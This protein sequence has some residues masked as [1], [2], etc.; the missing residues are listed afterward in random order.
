MHVRDLAL[1]LVLYCKLCFLGLWGHLPGRKAFVGE[2][3]ALFGT[4]SATT[5][6]PSNFHLCNTPELVTTQSRETTKGTNRYTS[7]ALD[8]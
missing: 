4:N 2:S 5:K 1:V 7:S 3:T 8:R 6:Q